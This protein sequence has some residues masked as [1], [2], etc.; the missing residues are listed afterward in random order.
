M[1][2]N[3]TAKISDFFRS[4][5]RLISKSADTFLSELLHE[6]RN[7]RVTESTKVYLLSPLCE[8]PVLLC[9]TVSVGEETVLELLSLFTHC[10]ETCV[11]FRSYLL[12]T[13]TTVLISTS[14]VSNKIHVCVE[15]LDLL[16]EIVQHTSD[17]SGGSLL[18]RATACECLQE[19]ETCCPGLLAQRL[20][21][22]GGLWSKEMSRLHQPYARLHILVLKNCVY[23]LAVDPGSGDDYLKLLVGE[24]AIVA[25]EADEEFGEID[26]Y[27]AI[28]SSLITGHIGTVP[29]LQTERDCKDLRSVLSTTLENSF[30]LTPLCQAAVLH[31]LMEVV[32]MVPVIPP[33]IFRAQLLRILGTS[34]VCLFHSTLLMK[35]AY[36]DSLFST[37]D[38]AFILRRL[39]VLSQH[40]LLSKPEKLFFMDYILHF[41]ENRPI[42]CEI[43][44]ENPPVLLTPKLAC[45]LAPTVLNDYATMLARFNLLL[46]VYQEEG[47]GEEGKGL[48]YLYEHLSLLLNILIRGHS[49][50]IVV[51]FF[52][53]V[54]LFLACF[55]HVERYSNDIA[56]KLCM[57][58]HRHN[59][60]TL[61]IL[62]LADQT[63]DLFPECN[64]SARLCR[65][66]QGMI[67]EAPPSQ[68][69]LT[70]LSW[71][72]K[73]LARVAE[74]GEIP[75]L[76]TLRLLSNIMITPSLCMTRDW[77]L[78]IGVLQLC[79][80]LMTHP[81]L[82]SLFIFLTNILQHLSC[83]YG[84]ADIQ[85]HARLYYCLLTTLSKEKLTGIITQGLR[86]EGQNVK[87]SLSC[88]MADTERLTSVLTIHQTDK[89]VLRLVEL[90]DPEPQGRNET[91]RSDAQDCRGLEAYREQ[92]KDSCF[93]SQITLYYQLNH[94]MYNL[95]CFDQVFSIRLHFSIRDNN[96]EELGV[97]TV[98]C[99]FREKTSPVVK[100][101]LKPS[102]PVPITL[103]GSAIFTTLNG[104]SWYTSLPDI[105]MFF[106]QAFLPLDVP[107]TW[108]TVVKMSLFKDLWDEISEEEHADYATALFCCQLQAEELGSIVE[109][110]L[111]PFIIS[112]ST[113]KA[114]FKLIFFMSPK[115]HILLK[116][117]SE[118][119]AVN[120]N[121][122]TDN[123][124]LLPHM[125][126]FLGNI[127]KSLP[128]KVTSNP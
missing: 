103:S 54:F 91:S 68:L 7:D 13:L 110:H 38:E 18:F 83:Y 5:S 46:L 104:F 115:F 72:L 27:S 119:D 22:I 79:R 48:V 26:N 101:V 55:C 102:L 90:K 17:P 106:Q 64:W 11:Q 14:C 71:H 66:L 21:L 99:L 25:S 80:R 73:V 125:S 28:L 45:T 6:L 75:Q 118:E 41:P 36:T 52:R 84:D 120:F 76:S 59:H 33:S 97:F 9:P 121:I 3:W 117:I 69:T 74:E 56:D 40:P 116:I 124:R 95:S 44:N 23:Q 19:L 111:L 70:D 49:Q 78:G 107:T 12:I 10:P 126:S 53:A 93:G 60:L 51:T 43:G 31:R 96:Y 122:A 86:E 98:P 128:E 65:A 127:L 109:K 30:L 112:D 61:H 4:P 100:L 105:Q 62:N 29:I 88:I 39:V 34:E 63:S 8:Q 89:P 114:E 92:F 32:A 81:S 15:F 82:D 77:R 113:N 123:W 16:L 94:T 24:N 50:E 42:G 58:Y 85:D 20:E 87:H 47:D 1:A 57:L 67:T 37:D 35:C 2:I 108:G